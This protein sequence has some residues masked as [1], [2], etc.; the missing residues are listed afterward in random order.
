MSVTDEMTAFVREGLRRYPEVCNALEVFE[1]EI[2][3]RLMERLE[4]KD[5]WDNF[6]PSKGERGRGKALRADAKGRADEGL[7]IYAMQSSGKKNDGWMQ[8]ELWWR[9]KG[10]PQ[11]DLIAACT[12][13]DDGYGVTR[14]TKLSQPT[15][16]VLSGRVAGKRRLYV[17][18][19]AGTDIDDALRALLD[20]MDRALG[21]D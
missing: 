13:Y 6:R 3:Q 4:E 16:P 8:L 2:Q 14:G 17:P 9:P 7:R 1:R 5:H 11:H 18:I 12:R 10:V 15:E 20:Q 19:E 21:L